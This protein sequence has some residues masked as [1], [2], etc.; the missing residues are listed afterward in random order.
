MS[1]SYVHF[2]MI[3][4]H[5]DHN[6][7]SDLLHRQDDVIRAQVSRLWLAWVREFCMGET[8]RNEYVGGGEAAGA[9]IWYRATRVQG[10]NELLSAASVSVVLWTLRWIEGSYFSIQLSWNPTE[11]RSYAGAVVSEG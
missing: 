7:H 4:W 6:G 8:G 10:G 2:G 1:T 11:P 9:L 3:P 5:P